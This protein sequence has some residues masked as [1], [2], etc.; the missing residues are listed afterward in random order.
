[1]ADSN[2]PKRNAFNEYSLRLEGDPVNGERRPPTL[3]FIVRKNR[4][5][6]EVRTNVTNDK[7]YGRIQG[8]MS[9]PTFYTF[10]ELLRNLADGPADNSVTVELSDF[11][12]IRGQNGGRGERSKEPMT[13]ARVVIGK[14]KEGVMYLACISWEQSRPIIKFPFRSTRFEKYT[15]AQKQPLAAGMLSCLMA[16]GWANLLS[17]LTPHILNDEYWEKPRDDNGGQ[18]GGGNR[19][20][21]GGGGGNNN[22]GGN[23]QGGGGSGGSSGGG[24]SSGGDF[25]DD[26]FPFH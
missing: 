10:I 19:G 4:P 18:Q 7:D 1:M 3:G 9:A 14:D 12:F 26:D 13:E 22:G 2:F 15:D 11:K 5:I 8:R 21:W 24:A 17:Q 23:R 6:I 16:R 25:T 20:S